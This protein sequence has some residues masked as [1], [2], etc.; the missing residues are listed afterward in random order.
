MTRI[1]QQR[2][3]ATAEDLLAI[4]EEERFHEI[5]GGELVRK[6]MPS[7]KHG[8]AQGRVV[9]TVSPYDRRP[10][11]PGPGG[12]WFATEV[13]VALEPNEIYRPDV[14]GWRRERLP[15]L[16]DATPVAVRPDWIC[17]VLSP[18]NKRNDT[19]KKRRVYH[20]CGVPHFWIVDPMEETLDV[21]RWHTDGY[22]QVLA[23]ERGDRVRPEPFDAV[24]LRV[25]V[26][27]G[28]DEDGEP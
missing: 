22:L 14:V 6:A 27:F 7:A 26:L 25:G 18:S 1:V 9:R 17:E 24:E 16:P 15:E 10:Q 13:E 19:I 21:Y 8:G 20:R 2:R 23:A 28:E 4:P 12:W 5:I 3:K 11:P